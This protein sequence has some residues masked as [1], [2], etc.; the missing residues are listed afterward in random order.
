[1]GIELGDY[2]YGLRVQGVTGS[3]LTYLGENPQSRALAVGRGL[4]VNPTL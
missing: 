3:F 2:G 4:R 1:M